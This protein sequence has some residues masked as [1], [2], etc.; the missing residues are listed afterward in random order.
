MTKTA[1]SGCE[2]RMNTQPVADFQWGSPLGISVILFLLYGLIYI[3]I[4]TL[5]PIL[6]NRAIGPQILIVSP[7]TDRFVFG[8]DPEKLL[9]DDPALFRLRTIL[10]TLLAG[11]MVAAGCFHL[12]LT[13]FGL[14]QGQTW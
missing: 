10:L 9:H 4:G 7:R 6:L 12:A 13:W 8:Q 11:M 14:R 1:D 5:T 2:G 3:L